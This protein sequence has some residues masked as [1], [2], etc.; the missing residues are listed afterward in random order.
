MLF[1]SGDQI[2]PLDENFPHPW[3]YPGAFGAF[4]PVGWN[5]SY[6]EA[7]AKRKALGCTCICHSCSSSKA[8]SGKDEAA[9][10]INSYSA[11]VDDS[12]AERDVDLD[13]EGQDT[14]MDLSD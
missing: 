8:Q 13:E 6:A 11:E 9:T 3:R 5:K 14:D 4:G 2:H 10:R 12:K 1:R 7:D